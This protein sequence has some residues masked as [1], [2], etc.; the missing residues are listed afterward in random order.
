LEYNIRAN[1]L[2]GYFDGARKNGAAEENKKPAMWAGVDGSFIVA[3]VLNGELAN[4]SLL[5]GKSRDGYSLSVTLFCGGD[6]NTF[7]FPINDGEYGDVEKWLWRFSEDCE[8]T[9]KALQ[10]A[11]NARK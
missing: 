8:N 7:Y 9:Y 3:A 1:G 6:K 5:F 4:V 10:E 2:G 11:K